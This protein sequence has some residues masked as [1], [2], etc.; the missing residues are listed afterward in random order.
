MATVRFSNE[1]QSAIISKASSTFVPRIKAATDSIPVTAEELYDKMFSRYLPYMS[2]LPTEFFNHTN[3]FCIHSV[4]GVSV[5]HNFVLSAPKFF[6]YK[7]GVQPHVKETFSYGTGGTNYMLTPDGTGVWDD[8]VEMIHNRNNTIKELEDQMNKFKDNLRL[9]MTTHSTLA[10]ALK[11][12]PPLWDF[13]PDSYKDKHREIKER[14][15]NDA[16]NLSEVMDLNSMTSV[17]VASKF[18]GK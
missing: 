3:M 16:V 18:L 15:K 9:I 7:L 17:V 5:N 13:V 4:H 2:S 8:L 12:W 10:P 11:A 14:K 6:P 1:L